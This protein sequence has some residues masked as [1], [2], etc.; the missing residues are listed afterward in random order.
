MF[1]T[2]C[3][4]SSAT[5]LDDIAATPLDGAVGGQTWTFSTGHTSGFLS[6]GKPEF[7]A[8]LYPTAFTTCGFSE[9]SGS[10]L[11]VAIPKT[12]GDYEMGLSLNMTFVDGSR[13]LVATN[14]RI[15]VDEVTETKVTGGLVAEYDSNNEVNGRFEVALCDD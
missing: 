7:F 5:S 6:E 11:I 10:H 3:S 13:N 8:T 12:P 2:G 15:V 1:A 9:P 4:V 14:G